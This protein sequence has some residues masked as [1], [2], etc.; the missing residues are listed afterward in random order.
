M[1]AT[2]NDVNE[3]FKKVGNEFGIQT[4]AKF[5]EF[6][7]FKVKWQR[8]STW[9]MFQVTDYLKN[10]P[11]EVLESLARTI[12]LKFQGSDANYSADVVEWLTAPE[13]VDEIQPVYIK[14]DRRISFA[15]GRH[16]DLEASLQRLKE[17]GLV[18][19]DEKRRIY[20][21]AEP[22]R[23]IGAWSSMLMKVITVNNILDSEEVPNEV[24]DAV[25]LREITAI[26]CDYAQSSV[27]KKKAV[28]E[29]MQQYPGIDGI[30]Q[31]LSIHGLEA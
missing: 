3:A 1:S 16:K 7:D 20:W 21:S 17:K 23:T 28:N 29:R 25:L 12:F 9:A 22:A 11:Q 26:S 19:D 27:D 24:L 30:S 10:A 5:E 31:W 8:S 6:R 2:E 13:F 14:R 18:E 4:S 15:A